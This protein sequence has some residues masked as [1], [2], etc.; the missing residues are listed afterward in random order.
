MLLRVGHVFIFDRLSSLAATYFGARTL[1][2][3]LMTS[4]DFVHET[5]SNNTVYSSHLSDSG[6]HVVWLLAASVS[7]SLLG[8][9]IQ[10]NICSKTPNI[11]TERFKRRPLLP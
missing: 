2:L 7:F 3:V 11:S 1:R 5:L 6:Q 8:G 10:A 4:C 9:V